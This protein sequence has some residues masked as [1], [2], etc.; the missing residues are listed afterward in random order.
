MTKLYE[1]LK[2]DKTQIEYD[3][4]AYGQRMIQH[5]KRMDK[6]VI[7]HKLLDLET[8]TLKRKISKAHLYINQLIND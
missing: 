3:G 5:N 8:E 2:D 7:E 4:T 1:Y 6:I